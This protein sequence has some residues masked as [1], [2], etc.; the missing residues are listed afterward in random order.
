MLSVF[1]ALLTVFVLGRVSRWW[2]PALMTVV[3][4][5]FFL[6]ADLQI[7]VGQERTVSAR[8]IVANLQSITRSESEEG[9]LGGTRAWRLMWWTDIVNYTVNGPYFWTGKGFG[10]N[11]ADDDGYQ[12]A[13]LVL[14]NR[15]PHNIQMTVLARAGVPGLVIW[16]LLQGSFA[17]ALVLGFFRARRAGQDWWARV[18]LWLLSY[19]I[20]AMVNA[21]FDVYLEGPQGAIWF[22]ALFGFSMAALEAQR[23]ERLLARRAPAIPAP[24]WRAAVA[25]APPHDTRELIPS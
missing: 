21:A 8:Q 9:N 2:K 11:L 23:R 19:W 18:D 5:A 20:A 6:T 12:A 4:G 16:T 22:W 25:S 13:D 17:A 10:I 1:L 14:G 15:S 24:A 3:F 7:D